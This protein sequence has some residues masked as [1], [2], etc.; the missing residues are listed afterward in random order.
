MKKLFSVLLAAIML[1]SLVSC[2]GNSVKIDYGES[3]LYTVEEMDIVANMLIE[4][5][6]G[7]ESQ[8]IKLYKLRFMG[9]LICSDQLEIYKK[10]DNKD[11]EGCIVFAATYRIPKEFLFFTVGETDEWFCYYYVKEPGGEWY[12]KGYGW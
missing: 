10:Q 12:Q 6:K 4:Y 2:S 5:F 1:F 9:D 3:E 8:G 7:L 11:Y